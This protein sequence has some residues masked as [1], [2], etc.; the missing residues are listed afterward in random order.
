MVFG[1][2]DAHGSGVSGVKVAAFFRSSFALCDL[3]SR[4]IPCHV[5]P[6]LHTRLFSVA[7][8][9]RSKVE[10]QFSSSSHVQSPPLVASF[11]TSHHFP[12]VHTSNHQT[13]CCIKMSIASNPGRT[14][15]QTGFSQLP[16]SHSTSSNHCRNSASLPVGKY[17][18]DMSTPYSTCCCCCWYCWWC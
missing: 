7:L 18:P 12:C 11:K 9:S 4:H 15:S 2:L 16:L 1:V 13:P 8:K 10:Y 6:I 14:P 3:L 17:N 5:W